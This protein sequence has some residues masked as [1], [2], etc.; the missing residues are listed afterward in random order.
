[1]WQV[2]PVNLK[3]SMQELAGKL[4]FVRLKQGL[5]IGGYMVSRFLTLFWL[6]RDMLLVITE[7]FQ[8]DQSTGTL[9]EVFI[10]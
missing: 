2:Y 10:W 7:E 3:P 4:V 1:M 9:G 8:D 6:L 5:D